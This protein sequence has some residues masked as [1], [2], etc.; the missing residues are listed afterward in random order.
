MHHGYLGGFYH[1]AFAPDSHTLAAATHNG[2]AVFSAETGERLQTLQ[3]HI[4]R[5]WSVAYSP[6]HDWVLASGGEDGLVLIRDPKTGEILQRI[7]CGPNHV[8]ALA[9][10]PD[11]RLLAGA[12]MGS[13]YTGRGGPMGGDGDG[14][15]I[16]GGATGKEARRSRH[17]AAPGF[18][19]IGWR[20]ATGGRNGRSTFS[21]VRETRC[22][23]CRATRR[24]CSLRRRQPPASRLMAASRLGD[25]CEIP[26]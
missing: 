6:P 12:I 14:H 26:F 13:T 21:G 4:G 1:L 16:L 18:E 19:P 24:L 5:V 11:A 17:R 2:V 10:S 15:S 22:S 7:E 9:F 25:R 8:A 20:L 3:G 23:A